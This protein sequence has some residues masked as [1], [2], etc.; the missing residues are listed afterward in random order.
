MAS[1]VNPSNINGNFPIAGQDNDSQGFRDNFTNIRNN[2]T[3]IKQEVEDLQSK[4]ILK[5]ALTGG[6]L[7]NNFLGSQIKNA[8]MKNY[9]ETMYDWG[10]TSGEIQLDLA[11]GNVH[12]VYTDG[13]I[14]I[15]SVIKNWP[16][17]LQYSRILLYIT[18][19]NTAHTLTIPNNITTTLE[20]IP[21][22][23]VVTGDNV[24]DFA[25]TS[26]YIYEFSSVDSGTTVFVRELTRGN[27]LFRDPNFY[28]TAI[29]AGAADGDHPSGFENVT[30]KVGFGN[31][32][33]IT[34]NIDNAK[35]DADGLSVRGSVTSFYSLD[36]GSNDS[37]SME[38]AGFTVSRARVTTPPQGT[39]V[40]LGAGQK[41]LDGD[42]VGY[43]NGVGLTRTSAGS[44]YPFQQLASMQI[45]AAGS[46]D[47]IGGNIVFATK[48]DGA[49]G[50]SSAL[51]IDNTQGV[52]VQGNLTV[53]GT[54]TTVNS[55]TL[56]VDDKNIVLASGAASSAA[57]N[58]AGISVDT[59]NARLEYYD[60]GITG[61]THSS[62][63]WSFNK[64]LT[65]PITT[66]ANSSTSGAL[67]V[68]G[69]AGIG[70]DLYVGGAFS[71][72]SSTNA[73][74]PDTGAFVLANGGMGVEQNIV[75]NGAIFANSTAQSFTANSGSIVTQGGLGVNK[76]GF[77]GG[78]IYGASTTESTGDTTG[79]L[80]VDG[81]VGIKK[82][83]NVTG[84]VVIT[85][86]TN[87][88]YTM[89]T[90][91]TAYSGAMIVSGGAHV[92]K[93][94]NVGNDA[95]DGRIIINVP[96]SSLDATIGDSS[97]GAL[98]IGSVAGSKIGGMSV[99]GSFNLGSDAGGVLYIKNKNA[100]VG[101]PNG[102]TDAQ[103]PDPYNVL[104]SVY[105]AAT[106]LGGVNTMGNLFIGQPSAGGSGASTLIN[107]G[108]IYVQSGARSTSAGS[109]AIVIQKVA[110]PATASARGDYG[111][112]FSRG[113]LG[114]EGNL[115]AVGNVILGGSGVCDTYSNV[116]VDA[117]TVGLTTTRAAL[118]VKGGM[119]V[120]GITQ[121]GG[122]LVSSSATAGLASTKQGALVLAAGG[123]Y[124]NG[125]SFIEGN[126]VINSS[127]SG[128]G[129]GAYNT[130]A[131]VIAGSGGLG[132][133]GPGYF[134]GKIVV[135]DATVGASGSGALVLQ[136][137][138]GASIGG[139]MW[140]N[141][142]G[143][144]INAVGAS[145]VA[146]VSATA[147]AQSVTLATLTDITNLTF[148]AEANKTYYF[149]AWIFHD[150]TIASAAAMTKT[151]T[152]QFNAGT[153]NFVVEQN[154]S[155]TS[156]MSY[157]ASAST[158][159]STAGQAPTASATSVTGML[160]KI[161]G[162]FYH[163]AS[164]AVKLQAAIT[165][166]TSPT[167]SIKGSTFFKWTK[168]N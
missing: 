20:A 17:S 82:R 94:L 12:K 142:A 16:S 77:F 125:T 2:F 166:G 156:A 132:V 68:A 57:A 106:I 148:T 54:T 81:G 90:S 107:S 133:G 31:L 65:I 76:V 97:T 100:A 136:G 9:S 6:T 117:T 159:G 42:L 27:H 11:L 69:G 119:G 154:V 44:S 50:M 28:F 165:G 139:Y 110:L 147:V 73:T 7:D 26:S 129:G 84:N 39:S 153:C 87:S 116:V 108:N 80:V 48:S 46:S 34:G 140:V 103:T 74:T 33:S 150:C 62:D 88:T 64:A 113:G 134:N 14:T 111:D 23:R 10:N 120:A 137:N 121:L 71:L 53:N 151:F 127:G 72:T 131:L 167:L 61:Y 96:A 115:Y 126:L 66:A 30:L 24:I 4:A 99:S 104:S 78:N 3:F 122:N 15:N 145:G 130:G 135:S 93:T 141:G 105:G 123:A 32:L 49:S 155:S 85:S 38:S 25:E 79:A 118:V 157:V 98:V 143:M 149:E 55:A 18:I 1:L 43:F 168:L 101:V 144:P 58:G 52:T 21:G 160:A 51:I 91:G 92:T 29:G 114:M 164:T 128:S 152:V 83:L 8:Q 161:T 35:N 19:S 5:S 95:G 163:T 45:Y 60:T 158:S 37:A 109:G 22:L 75:A 67:V 40:T 124:I 138:A 59:V 13:S 56:T 86:G 162:T 47:S 89:G 36:D 63:R 102:V 41:V 70:G 146:L 112:G